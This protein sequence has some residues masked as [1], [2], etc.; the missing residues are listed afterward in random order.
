MVRYVHVWIQH[1]RAVRVNHWCDWICEIDFILQQVSSTLILSWPDCPN[2]RQ[3]LDQNSHFRPPVNTLNSRTRQKTGGLKLNEFI[4]IQMESAGDFLIA[5][6][7]FTQSLP[8]LGKITWSKIFL[9]RLLQPTE[10]TVWPWK[11]S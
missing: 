8:Q 11:H 6:I 5:S 1:S 7:R 2:H 4:L 3:K 10:Q 9:K